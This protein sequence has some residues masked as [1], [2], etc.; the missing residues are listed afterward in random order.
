MHSKTHT[1]S[2][3]CHWHTEADPGLSLFIVHFLMQRKAN[4]VEK[5]PQTMIW[6][7][8]VHFRREMDTLGKVFPPLM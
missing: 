6:R 7:Q 1:K 8:L 2:D 3:D 5:T 4:T